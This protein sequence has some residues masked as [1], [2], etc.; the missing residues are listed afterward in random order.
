MMHTRDQVGR[1]F[2]LNVLGELPSLRR[3][4]RTLARSEID[5]EDLVHD[6]LVRAY[7]RRASFHIGH[8]LRVWLMS[9]LHNI[10]VDR[11]RARRAEVRR[12]ARVKERLEPQFPPMQ[13]IHLR[14]SQVWEAFIE[15]PDEQRA[16]LHLVAVEGLS[17][18]QAAA[19]LAIPVGTLM[20]RIARARAT[21]RAR[22]DSDLE[23]STTAQPT[24]GLSEA[25]VESMHAC[26]RRDRSP[27]SPTMLGLRRKRSRYL[28]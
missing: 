27:V 26:E 3:Y 19:T 7:E 14:L 12:L 25:R 17:Y 8:N 6:A 18:A 13:D 28:R 22:I 2:R 20:S 9:I 23:V 5:A 11:V 10:F 24:H 21:L 4:A 15:L 16:A 1:R